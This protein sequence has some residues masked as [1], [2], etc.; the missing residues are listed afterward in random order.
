MLV[1]F[2]LLSGATTAR[3]QDS[4]RTTTAPPETLARVVQ[5]PIVEVSTARAGDHTP[6]AKTVLDRERVRQLNWGQDTPMA[7]ATQ[8]G[9][10]AYSDA[11]NGI[12]Y[13]YLTIR[14]FPQRRISVLVNG[15]PLNDPESHEVYWIDHP[16][17]LAST[18][19]V[20]LQ[21]GVGS[22]LYGAASVGGS[23]NLETGPFGEARGLSASVS[24]G[25]FDTRRYL[26][27]L[28]PFGAQRWD[29][30]GRYSRIETDGYRDQSWSKLWSY[31][32]SAQRR[33]GK[34]LFKL[35]L[36]GGPEETH[37]AYLG[38]PRGVLEGGITGDADRDRRFNPIT[39]PG[40]ADHF[41]EPHYEVIHTW[42][43]RAGL[44]ASQTLFYFDG[45]GYYDE[46]RF[47]QPL[48]AYRLSPWQT[49]DPNLF[50][51]DSISY[52]A[53]DGST[54]T[55]D[56]Q[57]RVTV[58]A[59]DAIR[60]RRVENRH[61]GWIPRVRFGDPRQP[62]TVGGELRWHDG[63]HIGTVISGSGLPPGTTPD[64]V[65]YDYHPRTRS[66]GLFA[67]KEWRPI[68]ALTVTADAAWRHQDY[69]LRGDR[70]DGIRFDQGYDFALPRLGFWWAPSA[71]QFFGSVSHSR[72][73]PAFR[74]LYDA[75]GVGSVPLIVN[76]QPLVRPER[77]NDFEIGSR[78]GSQRGD[79]GLNLYRMDFRDELVYAGQFNT[80]LGYPIL[81]NAAQSVHQ[82]AEIE[83]SARLGGRPAPELRLIANATL[84]DN[85][86]VRYRE[87]FGP[88]PGDFVSYD[89]K[90]IGFFPAVMAN[91]SATAGVRGF[92]LGADLQHIG[93]MYLD[94]T[95]S[96]EG[97]IAPHAVLNL[98]AAYR[99]TRAGGTAVEI[100]ARVF[101]ALDR[102]YETG[103]YSYIFGGARYTD[104]IP[105]ATRNA[106]VSLR[107]EL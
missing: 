100:S 23:V 50:G 78:W 103:G 21:R 8:P 96:L 105:A 73:E 3:S 79:V 10:Y 80:D 18:A 20:Q 27:E 40:E 39:Y 19:G 33:E 62:I 66:A 91:L 102:R 43:P 37:L 104:F 72:R 74:D 11:G 54:L 29:F 97:S 61:F 9:V 25:S 47:G 22:S 86:F 98:G 34:H 15:V 5:L 76:G 41:F 36:Y 63:R 87:I 38:V 42:A 94:Q 60:R 56:A 107:V 49:L 7:L 51:A 2:A 88:G 81:G 28:G 75:E 17:L 101:N 65:Y 85:H 53:N 90:T 13:S 92:T 57:G 69:F 45:D 4:L 84:S 83:A 82:G 30:Y 64:H 26:V 16:D 6:V 106:L 89:G 48:A 68:D 1:A 14:G 67:R 93:R 32:F 70:F 46:Q 55:R 58:T 44:A 77:V 95:E 31:A 12:G 24:A 99:V 52:Y 59:F 35:N 71:W